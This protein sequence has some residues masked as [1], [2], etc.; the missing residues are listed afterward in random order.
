MKLYQLL[1]TNFCQKLT[2]T[3]SGLARRKKLTKVAGS[4]SATTPSD[5]TAASVD[6]S[7]SSLA[8]SNTTNPVP[9]TLTTTSNS[10]PSL[11]LSTQLAQ[12]I[13]NGQRVFRPANATI[14]STGGGDI[15]HL[16]PTMTNPGQTLGIV[17]PDGT[18]TQINPS[19]VQVSVA[20][21]AGQM[22]ATGQ[23]VSQIVTSPTSGNIQY[24]IIQPQQLQT[25]SID[26]Q[27]A[28]FIPASSIPGQQIQI[29]NQ[30]LSPT[31]QTIVRSQN[32]T[33][34]QQN[35]TQVIQQANVQFAQ[36]PAGTQVVR[37][38]GNVV[39]TLQLPMNAVQQ[40]IPI[41]IPMSTANGQTVYQ[42]IHLPLSALQQLGMGSQVTAQVVPQMNQIQVNQGN[43]TTT[44]KQEPAESSQS[45]TQVSFSKL[46]CFNPNLFL[47]FYHSSLPFAQTT[48]SASTSGQTVLAN[49]QL[50]NGQVGQLV[51]APPTQQVTWP[52]NTI[53][54]ANLNVQS[55]Q[56]MQQQQ[57]ITGPGLQG[58][59][60][61]P[62]NIITLPAG[63]QAQQIQPDPNDPQK[64]QI[65]TTTP[66]GQNVQTA[67]GQTAQFTTT[68]NAETSDTPTSGTGRKTRRVACTCPNCRDGEGRNSETK[69]KQH[70]CHIPGCQKVYGKTSHL[71]AHLRWHTGE[72]P[73][74]CNWLFCG[75]RFTRS[76]E[77]QRH[78]RTHTGEK[79]FQCAD[80]SKRF[81]RSDHLSKHLK[82]HQ[83]K[84]MG[85]LVTGVVMDGSENALNQGSQDMGEI[86][87]INDEDELAINESGTGEDGEGEMVVA[88]QIN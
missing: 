87:S 32:Q 84:K 86:T 82:T 40:T 12:L 16:I 58:L 50:P 30:I 21:S 23:T 43:A 26:G 73:F 48:N 52:G 14:I 35:Q 15:S 80:C 24:S 49:V 17:N 69:K 57:I 41:Q 63:A 67:S 9:L 31:N 72:R 42:T 47:P 79:R 61:A 8:T 27:E 51:A 3:A 37:Q 65:V 1:C 20:S 77:L 44:V 60:I 10:F 11:Q 64:W 34:Q 71:R 81:M 22:K 70:I 36:I 29:G 28:I 68:T 88:G 5:S 7:H 39:Q 62:G 6:Q 25:I 46:D 74:V 59:N 66:A 83:A 13:T 55:I 38:G 78:R 85:Q 2:L 76:D 18:I 45:T 33:N 19:H 56:G 53:N 54:L 4:A 75:K